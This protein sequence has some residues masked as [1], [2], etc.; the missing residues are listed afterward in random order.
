[1]RTLALSLGGERVSRHLCS[2]LWFA[3]TVFGF[4]CWI[5]DKVDSSLG[6]F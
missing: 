6:L 1:M 3:A 5:E 4:A 2:L